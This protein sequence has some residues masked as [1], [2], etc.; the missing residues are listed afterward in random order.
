M[1]KIFQKKYFIL[2]SLLLVF[3]FNT[4]VYAS[5]DGDKNAEVDNQI[6]EIRTF[7]EIQAGAVEAYNVML[8]SFLD[9]AYIPVY[10]DNYA[11]AYVER[12]TLVIQLTDVSDTVTAFYTKLLEEYAPI[13]FEMVEFSYN[14]L[15]NIGERFIDI[16]DVPHISRGVDTKANNYLIE[17]DRNDESSAVRIDVLKELA[18]E[19]PIYFTIGTKA[20]KNMLHGGSGISTFSGHFSFGTW[21][22]FIN[23]EIAIITSGHPFTMTGVS[24]SGPYATV[25]QSSNNMEIGNLAVYRQTTNS[26][27][28]YI[29]IAG[30]VSQYGDWSVVVIDSSL[31][32]LKSNNVLGNS[33][34]SI[35]YPLTGWA[36]EAPVG[37]YIFGSGRYTQIYAG[38]VT[39]VNRDV[40]FDNSNYFTLG[41][42]CA[43]FMGSLKTQNGDSGGANFYESGNQRIFCGVHVGSDGYNNTFYFS[44]YIWAY[45]YFKIN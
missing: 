28:S 27:G 7:M 36:Y 10:P 26:Y 23:G 40:L 17:L 44:P 6:A 19:N 4:M 11:G 42:T 35:L 22:K 15:K 2:I 45:P 34:G 5:S 9:E 13:A 25:R 21:G 31:S 24:A 20:Q 12:E 41:I 43:N 16:Y 29:T 37:T 32:Y 39:Y 38:R 18:A 14:E 8:E 30:G 3:I 1:F 33:S